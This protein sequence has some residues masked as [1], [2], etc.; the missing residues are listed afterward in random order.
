M[1][2]GP[3]PSPT[4]VSAKP[5][6]LQRLHARRDLPTPRE[7]GYPLILKGTV[8]SSATSA[9]VCFDNQCAFD[10]HCPFHFSNIVQFSALLGDLQHRTD[11]HLSLGT[12]GP[13]V[14]PFFS[15]A[16]Q[17]AWLQNFRPELI[18]DPRWNLHTRST[19][20]EFY[21]YSDLEFR[22]VYLQTFRDVT[23]W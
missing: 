20:F 19:V 17:S 10:M 23:C 1:V 3:P 4:P 9:L 7:V 11:V 22:L 21:Y 12:F 5:P 13:P 14:V 15:A 2:G 8:P 18:C 16:N 6:E